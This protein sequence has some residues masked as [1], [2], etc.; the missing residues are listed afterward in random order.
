MDDV[1][2]NGNESTQLALKQ[3]FGLESLAHGNDVMG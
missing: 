2:T 3:K 1:F